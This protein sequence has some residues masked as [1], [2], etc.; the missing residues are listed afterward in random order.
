MKFRSF[1]FPLKK[2]GEMEESIQGEGE[3]PDG[4]TGNQP[5]AVGG[6]MGGVQKSAGERGGGGVWKRVKEKRSCSVRV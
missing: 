6:N 4:D 2:L 5:F 1:I 3:S